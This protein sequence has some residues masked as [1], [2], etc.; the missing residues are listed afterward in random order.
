MIALLAE[1]V[2]DRLLG[3]STNRPV[4]HSPATDAGRCLGCDNRAI[5]AVGRDLPDSTRPRTTCRE[6]ATDAGGDYRYSALSLVHDVFAVAVTTPP[7]PTMAFPFIVT[8]P[9]SA[10]ALP[11]TLA[12]EVRAMLECASRLPCIVEATPRITES[13]TSHQTWLGWAPLHSRTEEQ[14]AAV[15]ALPIWNT[16]TAELSPRASRLRLPDRSAEEAKQ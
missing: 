15:S 9:P 10:R 11:T 7:I 6:D 2:G 3:A 13:P 16:N 14:L 5:R 8:A 4:N 1:V 12:P